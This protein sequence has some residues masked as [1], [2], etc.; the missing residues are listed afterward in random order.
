MWYDVYA[1]DAYKVMRECVRDSG[2]KVSEFPD[3]DKL[4]ACYLY[5]FGSD[6]AYIIDDSINPMYEYA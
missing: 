4:Y 6:V 1:K 5:L 3:V 2:I